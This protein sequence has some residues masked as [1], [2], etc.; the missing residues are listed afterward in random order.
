MFDVIAPRYDDFTRLFSFGMDAGWKRAAIAAA[1]GAW[2]DEGASLPRHRKQAPA[3]GAGSGVRYGRLARVGLLRACPRQ[4]V[5][6][7]DASPKMIEAAK[8]PLA[9]PRR[10]VAPR[11]RTM[12][13]DMTALI[14]LECRVDGSRD[15]RIWR[16][17]R[18]DAA[19]G[20]PRD[21]ARAAT[22][23]PTGRCWTSIDP[24]HSCGAR[25]CSAT[26]RWR[27]MPSAGGGTA[28]P[29]VYGYIARSI[30]HFMS[31]QQCSR[32]RTARVPGGARDALS[33]R[34]R[35]APRSVAV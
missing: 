31:W 5:T 22:R 3:H 34:R 8:R 18:A 28:I 20:H 9:F 6:A 15:R 4:R 19:H 24:S 21:A 16:A 27:A 2:P 17:Q 29:V 33:R 7:L 12:V 1:V 14:A 25:C 10:D 32:A 11:M 13:G 30:D 35:G 23:W 26:S